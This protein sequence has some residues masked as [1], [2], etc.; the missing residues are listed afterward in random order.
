MFLCEVGVGHLNDTV[1][2]SFG[3]TN[4]ALSLGGSC[5]DLRLVVVDPSEALA[6]HEF[7]V[8]VGM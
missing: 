2:V 4:G 5:N 3:N 7:S 6:P 8:E 1:T